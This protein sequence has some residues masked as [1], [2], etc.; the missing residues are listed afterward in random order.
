MSFVGR[1]DKGVVPQDNNSI[2]NGNDDASYMTDTDPAD[3]H[4]QTIKVMRRAGAILEANG[5]GTQEERATNRC[6]GFEEELNGDM[7]DVEE[8]GGS[9][10]ELSWPKQQPFSLVELS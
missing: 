4:A 10:V 7:T 2:D 3:V 6:R 5:R 9:S 1:V 8:E